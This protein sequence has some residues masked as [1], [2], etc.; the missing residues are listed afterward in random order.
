MKAVKAL[1]AR[2]PDWPVW[3][4]R[5]GHPPGLALGRAFGGRAELWAA[6]AHANYFQG[7]SFAGA[8]NPAYAIV[9]SGGYQDDA[10]H[11]DWC[12]AAAGDATRV[13]PA[14]PLLVFAPCACRR[15]SSVTRAAACRRLYYTGQGGRVEGSLHQAT[16][17]QF[18]RGNAALAANCEAGV[19]V[20][21]MRGVKT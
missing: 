1:Q 8:G 10:D 6:G 18:T 21:V 3:E 20:R 17:Q 19:P 5:H 11:G 2:H 4:R 7:I 14:R 16:A 13:P 12:A 15:H 9:L